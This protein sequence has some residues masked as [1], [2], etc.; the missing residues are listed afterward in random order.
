MAAGNTVSCVSLRV[1]T[2]EEH[3]NNISRELEAVLRALL[4][5]NGVKVNSLSVDWLDTSNLRAESFEIQRIRVNADLLT[6][7]HHG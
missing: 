7:E 3:M 6:V 2:H 5:V 4:I 1:N